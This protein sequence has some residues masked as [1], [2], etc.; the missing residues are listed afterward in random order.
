MNNNE[1]NEVN[2]NIFENLDNITAMKTSV[3]GPAAWFFLHSMAMAYP[4]KINDNNPE[5]VKIKNSMFVFLSNLGNVLPCQLCGISY[6]EYIKIPELSI[7]NHLDKRS[8]LFYFIYKIHEKV[9]DKLGVP[10]CDRPSYKQ[11]VIFYNKLRARGEILCSAT[12]EKERQQSLLAGCDKEDIEKRKFKNYK[13][14]IN[15]IDKNTN[16][17]LKINEE[18]F[19]DH[20]NS[21]D[22]D[23]SKDNK[24]CNKLVCLLLF[25]IFIL[26]IIIIF[27]IFL[28][29]LIL[30]PG[31]STVLVR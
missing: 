12:T 27:L 21:K 7:W 2:E 14:L 25:I 10:K 9:N 30:F 11:V 28:L 19:M 26:V 18:H 22:L 5:H 1:I 13:C 16:K 29:L 23:N 15:I 3:W 20:D 31:I 8:N 17:S 6:N 4:K 24:K